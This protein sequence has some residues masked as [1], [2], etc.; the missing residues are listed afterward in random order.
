MKILSCEASLRNF[1]LKQK[2]TTIQ[3]F[4]AFAYST[5]D[6]VR[7]LK[8]RNN[9]VEVIVGTINAFTDPQFIDDVASILPKGLWVDF[10]GHKSIHW[11][12]YLVAP[13]TVVIGSANLTDTGLNLTRDTCVV[14]R[15][16]SLYDDYRK[17]VEA[18]KGCSSDILR[19]NSK[20][21]RA[22]LKQYTEL[23]ERTQAAKQRAEAK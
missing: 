7:G 10:R 3:I 8:A 18:L 2:H 16:Q 23:H 14:L 21:F 5:A 13:M 1:L 17:N 9:S 20:K 15:N 6:F 4:S 12:L 22:A 19:P 11:K